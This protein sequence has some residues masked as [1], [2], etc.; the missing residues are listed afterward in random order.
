MTASPSA[1]QRSASFWRRLYSL[2]ALVLAINLV[3]LA[4]PVLGI[5]ALRLPDNF[6][7]RQTEAKLIAEAA[8]VRVLYLDA[9]H[10]LEEEGADLRG[11]YRV[12]ESPP[13]RQDALY[14]PAFP[15]IDLLFDPVLPPVGEPGPAP[16][17]ASE[18]AKRAGLEISKVLAQ[19]QLLNL[20]GVRVLDRSGVVV[21]TT[22]EGLGLCYAE[23][24]EVRRALLGEY[25]GVVRERA[26]QPSRAGVFNRASR[27]RVH[28]ALPIVEGNRLYG[29]AY[30]SRTS[31]SLLRDMWQA[32]YSAAVL[33]VLFSTIGIG[34]LL[35]WIITRPLKNLVDKARLIAEGGRHTSLN[36]GSAAPREARDLADALSAMLSSLGKNLQYI[37]EFTRSVS[38]E[39]KT[40]ITGIAGAVEL[41]VSSGEDMTAAQRQRFLRNIE[42]DTRRMERIVRRLRELARLEAM[43]RTEESCDLAACA[44]ELLD[45]YRAD[46]HEITFEATDANCVAPLPAD[47]AEVLLV[48]LLDNALRHGQGKGVVLRVEAGPCLVVEDRGPGIS[49]AN[50]SRVFERFFT[51]ARS[52]GGTGLGLPMVK[53]IAEAH[54]AVVEVESEP[55][56]TVFRVS[57]AAPSSA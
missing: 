41:L 25:H 50:L 9:L 33:I 6:L 7:H 5:L 38:H 47:L 20:S 10:R 44:A 8:Y 46:G 14:D 40:P 37:Q 15:Q 54:G 28:V 18:A 39:L 31:L 48:N 55:G 12:L 26:S 24:V 57:F 51:T 11:T 19:A 53:A 32:E 42:E 36:V 22:G 21:A 17:E 13:R 29:V 45:S 2:R 30:L 56:R 1:A 52:S 49:T 3:V 35:G 27:L 43:V 23:R 4:L 34:L 16:H